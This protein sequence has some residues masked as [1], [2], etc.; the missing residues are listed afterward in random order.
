MFHHFHV[1][2][3]VFF[4]VLWALCGPLVVAIV[5]VAKNCV[6]RSFSEL[7]RPNFGNVGIVC[8]FLVL[9]LKP[10]VQ[11]LSSHRETNEKPPYEFIGFFTI[12]LKNHRNSY[13]F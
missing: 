5:L 13:G 2:K 7:R 4:W 1:F 9:F 3:I 11:S 12:M 8:G 10:T 6:D